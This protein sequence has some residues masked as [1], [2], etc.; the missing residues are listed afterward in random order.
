V[1]DEIAKLKQL[2]AIG[3]PEALF[4]EVPAKLVTHY[5]QR[6]A[7]EKPVSYGAIRPSGA[8]RSWRRCAG[9]GSAK[10]WTTWLSC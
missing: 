2:R 4:A 9:S 5:R 6:A 1:L 8:T 3:L 7:S 10:S